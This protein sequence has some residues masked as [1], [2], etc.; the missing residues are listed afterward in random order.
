MSSP[1]RRRR[2]PPGSASS[3]D[4][5][6]WVE[7][8]LAHRP[9]QVKVARV[10][11][12]HGLRANGETVRCGE[13]PVADAAVARAAGVDRRVVRATLASLQADDHLRAVFAALRPVAFLKEAAR[14]LGLGVLEVFPE[15]AARPGVL[16]E[17]VEAVAEA[18]IPVRQAMAEDPYLAEEARL[19]L[20]TERPV[21]ARVIERLRNLPAVKRVVVYA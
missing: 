12:E 20:I 18:R 15:D 21:P 17:I 2:E 6:R 1:N 5:W 4:F 7:A 8:R 10:L 14:G 11:F 19:T 16:R 9:G 3:R 13:I